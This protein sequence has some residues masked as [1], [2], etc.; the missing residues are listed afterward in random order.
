MTI[1]PLTSEKGIS[2]KLGQALTNLESKKENYLINCLIKVCGGVQSS[3]FVR[4]I[5]R[6]VWRYQRGN[7][8][9]YIEKEQTT[10]W[11]KENAQKDKQRWDWLLL[12]GEFLIS[13]TSFFPDSALHYFSSNKWHLGNRRLFIILDISQCHT[14]S[15]NVHLK[16][17]RMTTDMF[18]V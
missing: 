16:T 14:Y 12:H 10:Q 1:T 11:P 3:I 2:S 7:Q 18:L 9:P 8:N 4:R 5:I 13:Q 15:K 6:R 17:L